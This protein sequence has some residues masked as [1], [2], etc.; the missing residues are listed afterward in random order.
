MKW[1]E[2]LKDFDYEEIIEAWR[3]MV[4]QL[5]EKYYLLQTNDLVILKSSPGEP[6]KYSYI[7]VHNWFVSIPFYLKEFHYQ[8]YMDDLEK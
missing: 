1:Q 6:K 3:E 8:E 2:K 7:D 4:I 5:N